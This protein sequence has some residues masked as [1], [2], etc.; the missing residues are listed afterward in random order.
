MIPTPERLVE[1][2]SERAGI[3]T[4]QL[5]KRLE[6]PDEDFDAL[7]AALMELQRRGRLVRVP[8]QGWFTPEDTESR[9]GTIRFSRS[10]HAYL[11]TAGEGGSRGFFIPASAAGGA[12]DGDFVL[13]EAV[14]ARGGGRRRREK[15]GGDKLP[16]ARVVDI[17]ERRREPV[18]GRFWLAAPEGGHGSRTAAGF[19]KPLENAA[20]G[21]IY[22]A[23]EDAGGAR[24]GQKVLVLLLEGRSY[25]VHPRGRVLHAIEDEGSLESDFR[26]LATE[27]GF[28]IEHSPGALAE[29]RAWAAGGGVPAASLSGREDLR[30]LLTFTID[31]D[32]AKDF[33]D[34]VSLETLE[35]G[36]ERLGVHIADVSHYVTPRSALDASARERGTSIYL[37]G[38]VVPMLPGELSN[39]LASLQPGEDRLTK[40]VFLDFDAQ[41]NVVGARLAR[42]VIR[43]RRRFTYDEVL[44]ILESLNEGRGAAGD[45]A[46]SRPLPS[47]HA[48]YRDVLGRMACLRDRL[49]EA[50]WNRGC[51]QLEI[52]R[53]RLTVDPVSGAVLRASREVQDPSHQLIEEFMLA[54]NEAV[55]RFFQA[56]GLPLMN[57]VHE[58]PDAEALEAFFELV[59][60]FA[61]GGSLDAAP[62]RA[63]SRSQRRRRAGAAGT[64]D[65]RRL[66]K[67]LR[68]IRREPFAPV[69]N[70]ALLRSLPHAS[71]DAEQS[72]HYALATSAYCHF[73]SP[74]RRYPDLHVHQTLDEHWDGLL[75]AARKLEWRAELPDLA[76]RSSM[77]ERRAEDAERS[78]TRLRL[79]RHLSDR[80][81]EVLEALI[82]SVHP[83]GFFVQDQEWL[84]DG[85]V[86]ISSL[87]D[88][89]YEYDEENHRLESRR[90]KKRYA[91][92]D[93][94]Q[95]VLENLDPDFREVRFRVLRKMGKKRKVDVEAEAED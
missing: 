69:L 51:L 90:L 35:N 4:R 61:E 9:T 95:V 73:T 40:S 89:Y 65:R 8:G 85:L 13:V 63:A 42:S 26:A 79:I 70:M 88:D 72:G 78:M 67:V 75:T 31:P 56:G 62:A 60:K 55:A 76:R 36:L 84:L 20:A 23:P 47:D 33:D 92:G 81:G 1:E 3:G 39:H 86:H 54:A 27:L 29:A 16:E 52:P 83:F 38:R 77:T 57:R 34:A 41:G 37:P 64:P 87:G 94:V 22:V 74:I 10:G 66:Q 12:F 21:E 48:E 6:T 82:V 5:A 59:A 2:I 30:G 18:R 7:V 28:P 71:Y 68:E 58:E 91:L 43:S 17:L 15:P 46:S 19:V 50:R 44:A 14:R 80:A 25:G 93:R 11:R 45:A 24:D 32:D 53:L 49:L